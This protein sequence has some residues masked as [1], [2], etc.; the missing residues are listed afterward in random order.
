MLLTVNAHRGPARPGLGNRSAVM[1]A[2]RPRYLCEAEVVEGL[3]PIAADEI[4]R[5]CHGRTL[6]RRPEEIARQTTEI[7]FDYSGRL[8]TL[9][10]LRTVQSVYLVNEFAV[11]RPRAL[12]G[13][14]HF[15]RILGQIETVRQLDPD[16]DFQSFHLAAAGADSAV[17]LR[18][19][20]QIQVRTG[21]TS[22]PDEGDL[23]IRVRRSVGVEPGWDVLTR[24]SPRPLATRPWRVCNYSGALNATI[25]AAMVSLTNPESEDVF[26]NVASGS[27][28]LMIERLMVGLARRVV[29]CDTSPLARECSRA[30]ADA[31]GHSARIEVFPWDARSLPLPPDSV[32]AV[33]TDLPFGHLVGSREDNERLYPLILRESARVAR[34]GA[35]MVLISHEVKPIE[36]ALRDRATWE[37][38]DTF[39]VA[40]RGFRRRIFVLRRS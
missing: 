38:R 34:P 7:Q 17:M 27:G 21:L 9:L 24:L 22:E 8:K 23:L 19:K 3:G 11:P 29:G 4:Q 5:R 1:P 16:A 33:C 28:T 6:L 13:D 35:T 20:E 2:A 32:D 40:Q 37:I 26:L 31:S 12:L 25:A 14:E 39:P 10:G 15:R 36:S 30:N 18:L